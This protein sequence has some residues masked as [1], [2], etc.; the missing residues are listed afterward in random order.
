MTKK[1]MFAIIATVVENSADPKKQELLD[2][3]NHEIELLERRSSSKNLSP[4]QK[5]NEGFK[6]AMLKTLVAEARSMT[7]SEIMETCAEVA[8]LKSQRV[9]AL[10]TQ[11]KDSEQIIRTEV[12]GKA[13]FS[14]DAQE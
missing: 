14:A 8:G 6:A 9:T 5:E 10:L 1:E 12:K 11:M 7:V 3:V 2:F 4:K 13:Y